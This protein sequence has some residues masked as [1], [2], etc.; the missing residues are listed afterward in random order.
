MPTPSARTRRARATLAAAALAAVAACARPPVHPALHPSVP[1]SVHPPFPTAAHRESA[2]VPRL[3]EPE[4]SPETELGR[5]S[6]EEVAQTVGL[7]DDDT[8]Q[9]Y[10]QAVGAKLA[11]ESDRP[12]LPW[13]F[14]VVD[15]P[16]PN[17][18]ALPGGYIFVTRGLV[19]LLN[20][21]AELATVLGHEIGHVAAGHLA[22]HAGGGPLAPLGLGLGVALASRLARYGDLASTG[23]RLVFQKYDREE[24]HQADDLGFGYMLRLDY[25]VR[26]MAG[27]LVTLRQG[28]RA[29][30]QSAL[31][32]WRVTHPYV[33]ERLE[34]TRARLASLTRPRADT[35][36]TA[37]LTNLVSNSAEYLRHVQGQVYGVNARRG[38]FQG[39]AFI[40]PDLRFRVDMPRGWQKRNLTAAVVA[41]SPRQDAI[42]QVT[43]AHQGDPAT[44]AQ[45]FLSRPGIQAERAL[46]D[47]VDG[48]P[49][50]GGYFRASTDQGAVE[51]TVAYFEYDGRTYQL[52][53]YAPAGRLAPY[54]AELRRTLVSFSPLVDPQLLNV[55]PHRIE[56]ALVDEPLSLVEFNTQNPSA[57]PLDDVA[58]LNQLPTPAAQIPAGE[59]V[60]RVMEGWG[61]EEGAQTPEGRGWAQ[62]P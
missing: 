62:I 31:P 25:D 5:R 40:H 55:Q 61:K 3:T 34:R 42:V 10:V 8:L 27:V 46:R 48:V 2:P 57:S 19:D 13:T 38:F 37:P 26:E 41:V 53:A 43:L 23:L 7:V 21:E 20:S 45:A 59:L 32:G 47:S 4:T 44:A 50:V 22:R 12:G 36:G 33:S 11:A 54:D 60:K 28:S 24:E 16:T 14:R 29:A 58:H 9:Q 52:L 6:A 49:A 1:P 56:V 15:D 18:F 51:G 30:G 39:S 17:A 35:T